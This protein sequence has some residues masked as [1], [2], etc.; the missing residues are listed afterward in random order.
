MPEKQK[1]EKSLADIA[2]S[3]LSDKVP[4]LMNY[5]LGF[6]L[7]ESNQESTRGAG[8]MGFK[9]GAELCYIPILF[10]NGKIK[11]DEMLYI[12]SSDVFTSLSKQWVEYLASRNPGIMGEGGKPKNLQQVGPLQLRIFSRPPANLG[13]KGASVQEE[14]PLEEP[15]DEMSGD[16][17]F[18]REDKKA[19]EALFFNREKVAANVTDSLNLHDFVKT[20]SKGQ[21]EAFLKAATEKYPEI[22]EKVSWYYDWETLKFPELLKTAAEVE[23]EGKLKEPTKASK[24]VQFLSTSEAMASSETSDKEKTQSMRDGVL[25]I[26]NRKIEEKSKIYIEDYRKR[27]EEVAQTGFYDILNQQG[28]LVRTFIAKNPVVAENI[29]A[30][31]PYSVIIDVKSSVYFAHKDDTYDRVLARPALDMPEEAVKKGL[32]EGKSIG[33]ATLKKYYVLINEKME[34]VAP[35]KVTNKM[36]TEG[37]PQIKVRTCSDCGMGWALEDR[38]S[39]L[40]RDPIGTGF[41]SHH[42]CCGQCDEVWM[43]EVDQETGRLHFSGDTVFVPKNWRLVEV[44]CGCD[45]DASDADKKVSESLKPA[46]QAN[47]SGIL[48]SNG[49]YPLVLE[50]N[51][52]DYLVSI[53][54]TRSPFMKRASA[55]CYLVARAG[56]DQEDAKKLLT[57]VDGT[58]KYASLVKVAGVDDPAYVGGD[59]PNI[60]DTVGATMYTGTRQAGPI[61]QTSPLLTGQGVMHNQFD[62][63]LS[64][65]DKVNKSDQEFLTRAADSGNK[66]VFDSAMIGS[67]LKTN[68]TPA[69]VEKYLPSFVAA[70]DQKCRLLL[71]FY[72]HNPE[73]AEMYGEDEM[74][75]FEDELLNSMKNDGTLILFLKQKA[76]ESTSTG[77]DALSSPG[78]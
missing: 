78:E 44:S 66:G 22:F 52:S 40:V 16:A 8:I 32:G 11:G 5:Y 54:G 42:S 68:R 73:F 6:E 27:F 21:Y 60:D 1:I 13:T 15:W 43:R 75:E 45:W 46:P 62:P 37:K 63:A 67:L 4:A 47:I 10:L 20:M 61:Q 70:L 9:I 51:A 69:Q 14:A 59:F 19:F 64:D 34:V 12:K 36:T 56:L 2:V 23:D 3:Q 57:D 24:K 25:I 48:Y 71:L 30:A 29:H 49:I 7:I 26:D 76:V 31:I 18:L 55:L 41:S 28:V 53:G 39:K 33:S 50:K 58:M 17:Q 72:W 74:A 38:A 65:W 77:M 35:F